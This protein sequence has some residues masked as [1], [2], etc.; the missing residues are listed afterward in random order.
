MWY[1]CSISP[2]SPVLSE[3]IKTPIELA[4][5]VRIEPVPDWVKEATASEFFSW[6]DRK[7]IEKAEL[8]FVVEYDAEALGSHDP[9]WNGGEARSIQQSAAEKISLAVVALW[10]AK[11]SVLSCRALLH[12]SRKNDSS[13]LRSAALL[14]PPLIS[15]SQEKNVLAADDFK[16]AGKLLKAIWGVPR[17]ATMWTAVN[18]LMPGLMDKFWI[19]R[20]VSQ[21]SVLEALFGAEDPTELSYKLAQR[22]SFFTEENAEN[23]HELYGKIKKAYDCRSKV[24]HGRGLHKLSND[25]IVEACSITEDLVRKS[26]VRILTDS[27]KLAKF[28]G[29]DR[30]KYLEG[31]IFGL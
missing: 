10:L 24:I 21:W 4:E 1:T 22:I 20:Y 19:V 8:A 3:T 28:D 26:F 11:P 18:M 31:I 13:S 27:D 15:E 23:R 9:E 6:Q 30:D 16:L 17:N 2:Q 7:E 12:F 14:R 25:K 29:K 5:G